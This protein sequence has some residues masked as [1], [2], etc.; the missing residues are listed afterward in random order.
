[1]PVVLSFLRRKEGNAGVFFYPDLESESEIWGKGSRSDSSW[2]FLRGR[3]LCMRWAQCYSTPSSFFVILI[4][5]DLNTN[6]KMARLNF[7]SH[8]VSN[9]SA[10]H[11]CWSC[12]SFHWWDCLHM[13]FWSY[14]SHERTVPIGLAHINLLTRVVETAYLYSA[15]Q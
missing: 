13:D 7:W 2:I 10:S 6:H 15:V 4:L 3:R 11:L 9:R 8:K 5:M 14:S 12:N 1:M